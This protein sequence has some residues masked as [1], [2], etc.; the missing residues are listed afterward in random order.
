MAGIL[1]KAMTDKIQ[2]QD[3]LHPTC[4]GQASVDGAI[5]HDLKLCLTLIDSQQAKH[6]LLVDWNG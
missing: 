1:D 4:T 2:M 5:K 6:E 3:L